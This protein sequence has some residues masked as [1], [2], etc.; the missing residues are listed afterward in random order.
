MDPPNICICIYIYTHINGSILLIAEADGFCSHK[1]TCGCYCCFVEAYGS[2]SD[3]RRH[4]SWSV[5]EALVHTDAHMGVVHLWR[6][7][8]SSHMGLVSC[9]EAWALFTSWQ[10]CAARICNVFKPHYCFWAKPVDE[11]QGLHGLRRANT[12]KWATWGIAFRD[13]TYMSIYIYTHKNVCTHSW[14]A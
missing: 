10:R 5:V 1:C 6:H 11:A 13:H 9:V 4:G 8:S 3:R 2:C 14:D 7:G 12:Q